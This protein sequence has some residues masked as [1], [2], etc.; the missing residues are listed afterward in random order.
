MSSATE[1]VAA[2]RADVCSARPAE[3]Q[4]AFEVAAGLAGNNR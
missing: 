4:A 1:A 2:P 3:A